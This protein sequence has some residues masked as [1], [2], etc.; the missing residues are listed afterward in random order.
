MGRIQ[1]VVK[2][3]FCA[4]A[5]AALCWANITGSISGLVTD[6]SGAVVS[7]RTVVETNVQTAITSTVVADDKGFYSFQSLPVGTY[8]I[9]VSQSGKKPSHYAN[10]REAHFLIRCLKH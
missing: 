10:W 3:A 1:S 2:I 6:L 8:T 9:A 4:L 7:G 5:L